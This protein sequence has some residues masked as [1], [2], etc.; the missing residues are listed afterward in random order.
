LNAVS[1]FV[2]AG[3]AATAAVLNAVMPHVTTF[4][5]RVVETEAQR[6]DNLVNAGKDLLKDTIKAGI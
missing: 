4:V 5:V 6:Y 1:G 2:T 3:G